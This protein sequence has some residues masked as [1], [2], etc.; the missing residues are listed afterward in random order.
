RLFVPDE[1]LENGPR[2]VLVSNEF[3]QRY[4]GSARDIERR[5]L[6]IYGRRYQVVGV[7]P[8]GFAYPAGAQVW[9]AREFGAGD[10]RTSHNWQAVGRLTP[11]STVESAR[12]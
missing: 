7:M 5:S 8:P 11:T 6:D 3:W 4:L 2:V 10:F 12:L 9:M 1:A